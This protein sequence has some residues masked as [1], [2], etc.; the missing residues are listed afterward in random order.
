[1]LNEHLTRLFAVNRNELHDVSQTNRSETKQHSFHPYHKFEALSKISWST[2]SKALNNQ[3]TPNHLHNYYQG[4]IIIDGS[5]LFLQKWKKC[6]CQLQ[7]VLL[8]IYQI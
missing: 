1:M 8:Y 2:M 3:S 6:K 5:L 4:K 7:K